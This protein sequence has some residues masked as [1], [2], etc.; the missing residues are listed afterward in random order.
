MLAELGVFERRHGLTTD[1]WRFHRHLAHLCLRVGRRAGAAN[2]FVRAALGPRSGYSR[3]EA[4]EDARLVREHIDEIIR[5]RI[6]AGNRERTAARY[7]RERMQ[8]PNAEWKAKAQ[9][10]LNDLRS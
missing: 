5:R 8:D 10:W 2:H 3:A 6:W 9:A 7:R 1:R 4:S